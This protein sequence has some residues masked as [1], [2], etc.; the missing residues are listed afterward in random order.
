MR[1][2]K[3]CNKLK[4]IEFTKGNW[5][6]KIEYAYT[7]RFDATHKFIQE[8]D[9]V[10]NKENPE[11]LY[12]HDNVSLMT[13]EKYGI[14]TQIELTA[15]ICGGEACAVLVLANELRKNEDGVLKYG[16]YIEVVMW[17]TGVTVWFFKKT[18][19]EGLKWHRRMRVLFPI[20][21]NVKQKLTVQFLDKYIRVLI[22]KQSMLL[23]IEELPEEVHVGVNVC[24]GIT[25]LYDLK[26]KD[27]CDEV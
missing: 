8:E 3:G 23:R 6:D 16:N 25:K 24:E 19:E 15:E 21:S 18:K 12:G 5:E 13:T 11:F 20:E 7:E 1:K 2:L 14:N 17:H 4:Y 10:R 22:G 26:I 9:C 27:G